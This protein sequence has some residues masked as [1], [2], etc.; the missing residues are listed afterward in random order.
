MDFISETTF[1]SPIKGGMPSEIGNGKD[2]LTI[3]SNVGIIGNLCEAADLSVGGN[4]EVNGTKA[5]IN[6]NTTVNGSLVVDGLTTLASTSVEDLTVSGT[7]ELGAITAKNLT[8]TGQTNLSSAGTTT[9]NNLVVNN[10][11]M[12]AVDGCGGGVGNICVYN[13]MA[14]YSGMRFIKSDGGGYNRDYWTLYN[15]GGALSFGFMGGNACEANIHICGNFNVWGTLSASTNGITLAEEKIT[16][17]SDL[18]QYVSGGG[19]E[20]SPKIK[21][22]TSPEVPQNCSQF[23]F[24]GADTVTGTE[25]P[26]IQVRETDTG[27]LVQ[28]DVWVNLDEAC[29][30]FTLGKP[31][32]DIEPCS[33]AS[34]EAGKWTAIVMN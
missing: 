16:K 29:S 9:A 5:T 19:G 24:E 18:A 17:W 34:T 21:R 33:T 6:G 27:K 7:T 23:Y 26:F 3:E 25:L 20:T 14:V 28:M 8:V 12:G 30:G 32:A 2:I 11:T 4:L 1:K 15:N 13:E 31:V 10:I 22:F